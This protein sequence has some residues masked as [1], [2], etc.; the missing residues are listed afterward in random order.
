M[1]KRVIFSQGGSGQEEYDADVKLV[2]SLIK[3][4]ENVPHILHKD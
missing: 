4:Y 1:R 3:V 2:A